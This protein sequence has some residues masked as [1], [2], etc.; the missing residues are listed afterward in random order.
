MDKLLFIILILILFLS[1]L[2]TKN[3]ARKKGMKIVYNKGAFRGFL[4]N[5]KVV[6]RF[7]QFT[8]IA[9]VMYSF[10]VFKELPY[11]LSL[12]FILGG[13]CGNIIEGIKKGKVTDFIVIG[14]MYYN[15][16]DF[17]I[18]GGVLVFLISFIILE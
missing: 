3:L 9:L 5:K 13:A 10:F 15:L 14:K 11:K 18:I 12:S 2:F 16:A 4:K 6:L 17:Y 1:D 8:S 7:L